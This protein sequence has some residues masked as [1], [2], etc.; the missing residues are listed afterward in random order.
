MNVSTSCLGGLA[1]ALS[2]L[3]CANVETAKLSPV[4]AALPSPTTTPAAEATPEQAPSKAALPIR[5]VVVPGDSLWKIASKQGVLGDAF[6]WPLLYRQNRDQIVDPDL[7]ESGEELTFNQAMDSSE[8][9]SAQT[10]AEETPP[11][12]PHS[13]ARKNLPLKY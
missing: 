13:G 2:M 6:H 12:V 10:L 11:Y 9:A 3:G 4:P 8:I 5:Y 1:L 7:I